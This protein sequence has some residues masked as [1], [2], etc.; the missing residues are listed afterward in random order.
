MS[1]IIVLKAGDP[2]FLKTSQTHVA[3]IVHRQGNKFI[4]YAVDYVP[5]EFQAKMELYR[6]GVIGIPVASKQPEPEPKINPE[7]QASEAVAE[8]AREEEEKAW[9]P[10]DDPPPEQP[11]E[12]KRGRPKRTF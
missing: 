4:K 9:V 1:E 10:V 11:A 2:E 12:R 3:T 5:N 8:A 6:R 7:Y